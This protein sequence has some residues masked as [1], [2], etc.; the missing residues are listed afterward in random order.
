M[1]DDDDFQ[2]LANESVTLFSYLLDWKERAC[3]RLDEL[4][5]LF[6]NIEEIYEFNSM[7]LQQLINSGM[8]PAKIAKCFINLRE[9][10]NVYTT[11]W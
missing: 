10:F 2:N 1:A 11:Y 8:E 3:L 9:R 4:Q 6:A 5:I 7:L